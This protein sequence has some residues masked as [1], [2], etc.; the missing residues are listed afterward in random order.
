MYRIRDSIVN[1]GQRQESSVEEK[2][3]EGIMSVFIAP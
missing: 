3:V 2:V 1:V